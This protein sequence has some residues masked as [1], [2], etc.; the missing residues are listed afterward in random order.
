MSSVSRVDSEFEKLKKLESFLGRDEEEAV[1]LKWRLLTDRAAESLQRSIYVQQGLNKPIRQTLGFGCVSSCLIGF[2]AGM[3]GVFGWLSWIYSQKN[4]D[5]VSFKLF[6]AF[7][8]VLLV[9]GLTVAIGDRIYSHIAL[10]RQ[11]RLDMRDRPHNVEGETDDPLQTT[12]DGSFD[13]LIR[14][15][16]IRFKWKLLCIIAW[17]LIAF[18]LLADAYINN[19]M[20]PI[21][22]FMDLFGRNEKDT[23]D[24]LGCIMIYTHLTS[25]VTLLIAAIRVPLLSSK[26]KN[27]AMIAKRHQDDADHH[28]NDG[29]PASMSLH[30]QAQG[31]RIC[32]ERYRS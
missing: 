19:G 12:M 2:E 29:R 23:L 9:I 6:L 4:D 13:R 1:H 28:S 7:L 5:M 8:V 3:A 27:K 25:I 24:L 21:Q 22:P 17:F 32:I 15:E 31:I 16:R 18:V 11:F 14:Y 10:N 20:I 30:T 26:E